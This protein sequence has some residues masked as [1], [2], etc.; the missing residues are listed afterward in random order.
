MNSGG[1]LPGQCVMAKFP[2]SNIYLYLIVCSD[3]IFYSFVNFFQLLKRRK[4]IRKKIFHPCFDYKRRLTTIFK[5]FWWFVHQLINWVLKRLKKQFLYFFQRG[6][7]ID[8]IAM[9]PSGLW[10]GR[11]QG[12]IGHFKFINVELLPDR[13]VFRSSEQRQKSVT[14]Q[15]MQNSQDGP[16]KTVEDLLKRIS[17]EVIIFLNTGFFFVCIFTYFQALLF[18]NW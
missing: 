15:R 17:L 8:I 18:K 12:R 7:T 3:F 2:T 1:L 4:I 6:D 16:P 10:R 5:R 11:C 13:H 9:N 14:S